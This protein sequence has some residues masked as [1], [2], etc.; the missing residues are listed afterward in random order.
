MSNHTLPPTKR[1][2]IRELI[3]AEAKL[4]D[5]I[6]EVG[7]TQEYVYKERGR[8]KREGLL[9]T[10][11]SLSISKGKREITVVKDQ[12]LLVENIECTD[13]KQ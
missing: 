4:N 2:R 3:L 11:Q 5:I 6:D 10:H 13:P 12:P 7:T 8:M 1:Q 9:V